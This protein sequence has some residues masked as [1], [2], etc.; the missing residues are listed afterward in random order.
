[1]VDRP[2]DG[3]AASDPL[4]GPR[5]EDPGGAGRGPEV[6][7]YTVGGE[8]HRG[9]QGAVYL[10]VQKATRRQ[11]AIKVLHR[12]REEYRDEALRRFER[13]VELAAGL[14]HPNIVTIH[15]SGFVEGLPYCVME[16]VEGTTLD[17]H[18]RNSMI[19]LREKL[20]LLE[21]ICAAVGFAHDAGVIHRDLKPG[22]IRV[23]HN[24][25]P[26]I[27]DFGL[28]RPVLEVD[29][30]QGTEPGVF[31]GT[32]DYASPEQT[33]ADPLLLSTATDV[34]ALGIVLFEAL[35]GQLPYRLPVDVHDKIRTIREKE[36]ARPSRLSSDVDGEL[37]TILLKALAKDPRRR[38]RDG[39]ELAKD[40]R[41]YIAGEAIEAR[42][43]ST[44]YR[45][46]KLVAGTV[47]R[48]VWTSWIV[49][50][51][52]TVLIITIVP[53]RDRGPSRWID[54]WI[55]G[56][57]QGSLTWL[58]DHQLSDDI[59][60]ITMDDETVT[61]GRRLA[62]AAGV[63][64]FDPENRMAWRP[65][66][67]RLMERLATAAPS[68]VVWDIT[69]T[70]SLPLLD[71]ILAR[72]IRALQ[73]A[74]TRVVLG[75]G[76][77]DGDGRPL[78][79]EAIRDLAD[80]SGHVYLLGV[81]SASTARG[82]HLV[83]HHPSHSPWPSLS[84]SAALCHLYPDR[85]ALIT[86]GPFLDHLR[87]DFRAKEG[88]C[89]IAPIM[90]PISEW[91]Q[92]TGAERKVPDLLRNTRSGGMGLVFPHPDEFRSATLP[93]HQVLERDPDTLQGILKN[94][95]VIIG[96]TQTGEH[97]D[98]SMLPYG[99]V[100]TRQEFN[101][102]VHATAISALLSGDGLRRRGAI[103]LAALFAFGFLGASCGSRL[104][105]GRWIRW[106]A[107]LLMVIGG[108]LLLEFLVAWW[109]RILLTP[110]TLVL[111]T[112]I[113]SIAATLIR[114]GSTPSWQKS[115]STSTSLLHIRDDY[116]PT[117]RRTT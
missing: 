58:S 101:C 37:E 109:M 33:A 7:G 95:V 99:P 81:E 70:R 8:I 112:C 104:Y 108:V 56:M 115:A 78:L 42:G 9:A 76:A 57:V 27:L 68:V 106:V 75:Y 26:V 38:Y 117:I 40:L 55:E 49:A 43:D 87:I 65:L 54:R 74:G 15:D 16:Y 3:S 46:R 89:E 92:Q 51:L 39:A 10:A 32:W 96:D 114:S 69:F 29:G 94:K 105:G 31:L 63:P 18:L 84:L 79:S 110:F 30:E 50:V 28:A 82:V 36:P 77:V 13:E 88:A 4:F 107:F 23:G 86:W 91:Q 48:H 41:H 5:E 90:I 21:K 19:T 52:L 98:V 2:H 100:D 34:Y 60:V 61:E 22:N 45:I 11:V 103:E 62:Q 73:D 53:V 59:V 47:A 111:A 80:A 71:P 20:D 83:I 102:F 6:P 25:E 12:G 113:A 35:T 14:R 72:G 116:H 17:A 1:M 64:L 24:G 97:A 44:A 93:Y 66:H 85:E 67:G